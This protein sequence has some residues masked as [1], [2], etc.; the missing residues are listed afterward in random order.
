MKISREDIRN[1]IKEELVN[2]S[3]ELESE[4]SEFSTSKPG[5]RV[6]REGKRIMSAGKAI[7]ETAYGQTGAMRKGLLRISEFV[8]KLGSTLSSIDSLKEGESVSNKLPTVQ[9]LKQLQKEIQK[10]E[11]M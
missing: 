11:R 9:E 10:L 5:R 8:H 1:L 6:I 3:E 7:N 4:M 2:K